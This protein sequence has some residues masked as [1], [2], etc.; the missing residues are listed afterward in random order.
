MISWRRADPHTLAGAYAMDA[1]GPAD[2]ASFEQHLAGCES[3]RA[4]IRGLRETAARLAAAVAVQP[5]PEMRA[6]VL[7]AAARTRQLPPLVRPG[8]AGWPGGPARRRW[9]PRVA[10]G[11][12]ATMAAVAIAFGLAMTGAQDR[13][14]QDQSHTRAIAS[15]LNAADAT[16][17]TAAVRTGGTATVVMSRQDRSLVF[18]A[19]GL[20]VLPAAESYELWLMGPAGDRPAGMLPGARPGPAGPMVVS[21][22]A[23]GDRVGLTV[24]PAGGSPRPSSALVLL[25]DLS[26]P[27]GG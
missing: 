16:M 27:P 14:S 23:A 11:L 15:V 26:P 22:L 3:C 9:L 20:R 2:R 17:L 8:S 12:A 19:A 25:L 10:L 21:G 5:P 1:V 7:P 6:A 18:T 24:E 4:E 13:L